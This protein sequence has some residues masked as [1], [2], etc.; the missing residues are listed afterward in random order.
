MFPGQLRFTAG[1]LL[2]R[3]RFL[4]EISTA[5]K[6]GEKAGQK[7]Q[8]IA[9][10]VAKKFFKKINPLSDRRIYQCKTNTHKKHNH[11]KDI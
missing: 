10:K 4:Q 3:V 6:V 9:K 11:K 5:K 7:S 8:K 1:E 2:D